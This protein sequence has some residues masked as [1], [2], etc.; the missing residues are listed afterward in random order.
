MKR[1]ESKFAIECNSNCGPVFYQISG[2]IYISNDCNENDESQIS[3]N[4]ESYIYNE[5]YSNTIF[6]NTNKKRKSNHFKVNDYEVFGI[7]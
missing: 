7:I 1:K 2:D 4:V 3:P 5:V 6:V